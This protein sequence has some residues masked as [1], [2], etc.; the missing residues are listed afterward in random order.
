MENSAALISR[1][2][3]IIP[4]KRAKSANTSRQ[5]YLIILFLTLADLCPTASTLLSVLILHRIDY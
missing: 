4:P 3:P 5:T 1:V 2:T